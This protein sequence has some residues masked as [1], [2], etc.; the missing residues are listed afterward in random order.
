MNQAADYVFSGFSAALDLPI[1]Q[2]DK[3]GTS[4]GIPLFEKETIMAIC[5]A[6][7][8]QFKDDDIVIKVEFPIVVV[9]DLHGSLH[10]LLRIFLK[11]GLPPQTHYLFLGD[12]VDR[13]PFSIEVILLLLSL[14]LL[15][16]E[17]VYLI[18]GNHEFQEI[19]ST[20]GFKTELQLTYPND[21]D[22]FD[23][24]IEAFDYMPLAAIIHSSY[25]CIH[26][27]ISPHLKKLSQLYQIERPIHDF[28]HKVVQNILWADPSSTFY[29]F[30]ESNRGIG[31]SF[32]LIAL[33]TFL[34]DNK[35]QK[36]IRGHEC[37][38]QGVE[39]QLNDFCITVFSS[40]NYQVATQNLSG[41]LL[42]DASGNLSKH[43]FP[44]LD[45][46]PRDTAQFFSMSV[47][48]TNHSPHN[49]KAMKL[50]PSLN[51]SSLL[52]KSIIDH[53]PL[54]CPRSTHQALLNS[55]GLPKV[56]NSD[57]NNI[58]ISTLPKKRT[59][60]SSSFSYKVPLQKSKSE[61]FQLE[62]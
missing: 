37:V 35:L 43:S 62:D 34:S 4:V 55:V 16:P 45:K 58:L 1:D 26:G 18:R 38:V 48:H 56:N 20:Y 27:G 21:P 54:L 15:F 28:R 17:S 42:I 7:R 14:Y 33:N 11:H 6:A 25:F 5:S 2:I 9:G 47:P 10:D 51:A 41:V 29:Y 50:G 57:G 40:S 60:R 53:R 61:R 36:L 32:G 8:D 3:V 22:I 49:S 44:P 12:Y 13:G 46:L 23:S 59:Y 24:F 31:V 52:G 19:A 30:H 39:T